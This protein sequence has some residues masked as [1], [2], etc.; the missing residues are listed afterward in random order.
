MD[1]PD[2]PDIQ[3]SPVRAK[4]KR[5]LVRQKPSSP[6][7]LEAPRTPP[8][9]KK[10]RVPIKPKPKPRVKRPRSP[11]IKKKPRVPI[12]PKPKPVPIKQ[13]PLPKPLVKPKP[14]TFLKTFIPKKRPATRLISSFAQLGQKGTSRVASK[15]ASK[16]K[17]K[18]PKKKNPAPVRWH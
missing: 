18:V 1:L 12:K 7:K 6:F 17:W 10:P 14:R 3:M 11:P 9:K 5:K 8:I 15:G 4:K 13:K 16:K 2:V